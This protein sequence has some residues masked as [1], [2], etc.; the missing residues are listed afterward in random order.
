MAQG[1]F[2]GLKLNTGHIDAKRK[3]PDMVKLQVEDRCSRRSA[4]IHVRNPVLGLPAAKAIIALPEEQR[5]PLGILLRQLAAEADGRAE[6][7]W[8]SRKGIMAAYWRGVS[9]Y[10]KHLARAIDP[11]RRRSS[12]EPNLPPTPS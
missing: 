12:P 5:R 8:R 1:T 3:V 4:R 6:D 2:D 11:R 7:A 9:T 10:A